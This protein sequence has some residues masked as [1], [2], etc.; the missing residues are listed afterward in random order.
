MCVCVCVCTYIHKPNIYIYNLVSQRVFRNQI[1]TIRMFNWIY[2]NYNFIES[3]LYIY[4]LFILFIYIIYIYIYIYIYVCIY[5][6][7]LYYKICKK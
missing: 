6:K 5:F 7:T 3:N 1:E 4:I 2:F